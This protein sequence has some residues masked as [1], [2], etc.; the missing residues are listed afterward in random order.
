MK[1][2]LITGANGYIG[3]NFIAKYENKFTF[4][5]VSLS[6]GKS[7]ELSKV[8]TVI[9][10]S[11]LVHQ[12]RPLPYEQY[13]DINTRQTIALAEKAKKN[14]VA[15]FIFFSTVA[16]YGKHGYF[17]R[18]TE[19]FS[20]QAAC[21]PNDVYG[22][23]KL[24][25][26]KRL[27]DM[28][29]PDFKVSVLRPPMVY[30]KGCPGNMQKLKKLV[31]L[32]PIL[33]FNYADNT[34]SIVNIDNLLYFT[35]LVVEKQITGVLIPQDN[36]KLSIKQIVETLARG[37]DKGIFLIRFPKF[38]FTRLLK[39]KPSTMASLYGSLVFDS[40]QSNQKTGYVEQA[41]AEQGLLSM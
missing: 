7:P 30:G 40:T 20:E 6:S 1:K 17:N 38:I 28:E 14:G 5:P 13:F 23:S 3:S 29:A 10:L 8:E 11:A 15:H 16:V 36:D 27:F 33:P 35:K 21:R 19:I 2:I 25:A 26:E 24:E 32:F 22:Q 4:E 39:M 34:R 18:Q 31:A 37:F 41:T 9:H 12:T